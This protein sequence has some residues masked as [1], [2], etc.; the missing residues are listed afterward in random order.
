[1]GFKHGKLPRFGD[2]LSPSEQKAYNNAYNWMSSYYRSPGYMQRFKKLGNISK[3][4]FNSEYNFFDN[5]NPG[6]ALYRAKTRT[7]SFVVGKPRNDQDTYTNY[8]VDYI[9]PLQ[10]RGVVLGKDKRK[11][12]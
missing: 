2:G 9:T 5:Y 10:T 4:Y 7:D 3:Q 8:R 12:A 11:L 6:E 1:M